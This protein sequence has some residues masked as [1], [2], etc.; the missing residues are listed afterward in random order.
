MT[1][2]KTVFSKQLSYIVLTFTAAFRDFTEQDSTPAEVP[3]E[4][5]KLEIDLSSDDDD[6]E[7]GSSS[8]SI[9]PER[10]IREQLMPTERS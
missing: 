5:D 1:Y 8:S 3:N 7:G 4:E 2:S 10:I 9:D 6:F